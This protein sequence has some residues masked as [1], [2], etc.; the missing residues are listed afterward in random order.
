[1]KKI[2]YE[3]VGRRYIPVAEYDYKL[4]DAFP[5]GSHLVTTVPGG[6]SRRHKI[7]PDYAPMIAAGIVAEDVISAVL[8]KATDLRLGNNERSKI[9]TPS[10]KAAWENLVKELGEGASRL[11]WPSAREAAEEG[12]KAMIE[13]AK[14]LLK[15][16]AVKKAYDHFM[17]VCELTKEHNGSNN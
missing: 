17:M 6:V 8:V 12:V 9:L 11:E 15:N 3:K 14:K 16:P 10:Q 2:Y 13:E 7:D 1:M 5:K 4:M